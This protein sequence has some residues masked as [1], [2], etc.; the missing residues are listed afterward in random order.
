MAARQARRRSPGEGGCWPYKTQAG[1]RWRAH[2]PVTRQDGTIEQ[3]QK[4]GFL[5]KTDGLEWLGDQQAAGRKGEYI[6][7]SKQKLGTYGREVIEGLRIG[8]QTRASYRK[9]WRLHVEGYPIASLRLAQLTGSRLT[10]HYRVLEKS[11][12]KGSPPWPGPVAAHSQVLAHDRARR[13]RP[14]RQGWPAGP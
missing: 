14:G 8:P 11:G 3:V 12:R 13:P 9:N 1:E 7:P 4:K 5:T 2:G 10:S 6:A